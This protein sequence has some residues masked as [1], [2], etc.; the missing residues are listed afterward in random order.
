[1]ALAVIETTSKQHK[2][3]LWV[4]PYNNDKLVHITPS[5]EDSELKEENSRFKAKLKGV[6]KEASEVL[7]LRL[8][9]NKG[10]KSVFVP[11][12]RNRN[13]KGYAIITFESQ[14]ELKRGRSKLLNYN[15]HMLFWD[16]YELKERVVREEKR[17]VIQLKEDNVKD[18]IQEIDYK[19]QNKDKKKT[20]K[21]KQKMK[22]N[23]EQ[24][25]N[26]KSISN[27]ILL[28]ILNRLD[29]LEVQQEIRFANH[30]FAN[31]S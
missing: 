10:A 16:G 14:E 28:R 4:L 30:E 22:V 11:V 5:D 18:I 1:M 19:Y 25:D 23:I 6:S 8:L 2:N 27:E 26:K 17:N 13:L 12:N 15:N 21:K 7:M 9:R 29:K 20:Q 31:H 24:V 3:I